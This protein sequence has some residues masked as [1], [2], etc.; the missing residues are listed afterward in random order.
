MSEQIEKEILKILKSQEKVLENHGKMLEKLE[1]GQLKLEK[2]QEKQGNEL[3]LVR[4]ELDLVRN[5]LDFVS[6]DLRNFSGHFAVFEHEFGLKVD[7]LF[8][9][10]ESD[11]K[12]HKEFKKDIE[13]LKNDSFKHDVQIEHL[14]KKIATA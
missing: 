3:D 5:G 4:N 2:I 11:Y 7:L 10:Y 6:K 13:S 14:S 1:K 8:E 12:E 9:K